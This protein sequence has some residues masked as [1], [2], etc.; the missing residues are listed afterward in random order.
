MQTEDEAER[1]QVDDALLQN[2]IN[3]FVKNNRNKYEEIAEA[4]NADDI[5]LAHR[6]LHT[7]KSNAG[8]INQK[9]LQ[10]LA[11]DME[12]RLSGDKNLLDEG[13]L[14][15]LEAELKAVL[16]E[17]TPLV[18]ETNKSKN[19]ISDPKEISELFGKLEP[20]LRDNDTGC[21]FLLDD[22]LSIPGSEELAKQIEGF[23]FEE[24][25]ITL[26]SLKKNLKKNDEV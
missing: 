13:Q 23:D 19:K 8:L 6:L 12:N 20:M 15:S 25:L 3:Y 18:K 5:K 21:L 14:S 2:L 10:E 24:A 22:I 7:L 26:E 16:E 9:N 17:L 4:I 1:L 11:A